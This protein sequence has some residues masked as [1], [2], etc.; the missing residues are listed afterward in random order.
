MIESLKNAWVNLEVI[1][2]YP[3]VSIIA[4]GVYFLMRAIMDKTKAQSIGF[5]TGG[6]AI[7]QAYIMFPK[8]APDIAGNVNIAF[9]V[10]SWT[11]GLG[12]WTLLQLVASIGLYSFAEAFG[13]I[14]RVGKLIQAIIDKVTRE[15]GGADDTKPVV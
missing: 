8:T 13:I 11:L 2:F 12:M 7:A 9:A 3:W 10:I 14:D 5:V 1:G 4:L 15:K 6:I